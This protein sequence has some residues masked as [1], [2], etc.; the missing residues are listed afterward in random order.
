MN[1]YQVTEVIVELTD[2]EHCD[3]RVKE[4]LYTLNTRV[5]Q[6]IA[7]PED[8]KQYSKKGDQGRWVFCP[9]TSF[10]SVHL[11]FF[12]SLSVC[13]YILFVWWWLCGCCW[14]VVVLILFFAS[15][16]YFLFSLIPLLSF[17]LS[18]FL[19]LILFFYYILTFFLS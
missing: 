17:V 12:F 1:I 5:R 7:G 2:N 11:S 16:F 14:A 4:G 18:F 9:Q 13:L 8:I 10:F 3:E 19:F 6:K 15:F